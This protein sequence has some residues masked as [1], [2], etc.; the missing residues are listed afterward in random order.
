MWCGE[1][2]ITRLSKPPVHIDQQHGQQLAGM[3]GR[4]SLHC[5][6]AVYTGYRAMGGSCG[7]S[8]Y[9]TL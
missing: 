8:S 6:T 5:A 1:Y 4:R 7:V 2:L 9:L 3:P